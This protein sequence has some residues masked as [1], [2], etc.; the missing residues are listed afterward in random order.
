VVLTT[1][2]SALEVRPGTLLRITTDTSAEQFSSAAQAGNA[3]DTA[4]HLVSIIATNHSVDA[5]P[6]ALLA[7]YVQTALLQMHASETTFHQGLCL[8]EWFPIICV[9]WLNIY[10]SVGVFYCTTSCIQLSCVLKQF[11]IRLLHLWSVSKWL[12]M[13]HFSPPDSRLLTPSSVSCP[14][15]PDSRLLTPSSVS[16]PSSRSARKFVTCE[17]KW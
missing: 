3:R 2:I 5:A 9:D 15:S 14:S 10:T 6:L 1:N 4:G 12:N 7:N 16:C 13:L 8:F 17:F 11:Y